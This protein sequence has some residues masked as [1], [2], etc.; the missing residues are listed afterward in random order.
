MVMNSIS[1]LLFFDDG[2]DLVGN[3]ILGIAALCSRANRENLVYVFDTFK[4]INA[5]KQP[6]RE[7]QL[8]N[9]IDT[10]DLLINFVICVFPVLNMLKTWTGYDNALF[11][12][13]NS[14]IP[15]LDCKPA[16]LL[17]QIIAIHVCLHINIDPVYL[18][19]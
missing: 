17:L 7:T 11:F 1:W 8:V 6:D 16:G 2:L 12:N 19:K 9:L 18:P 14:G 13:S 3:H 5:G 15:E 4:H 10:L